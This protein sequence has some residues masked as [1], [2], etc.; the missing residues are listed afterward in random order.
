MS[1]LE[2]TQEAFLCHWRSFSKCLLKPVVVAVGGLLYLFIS[3][4]VYPFFSSSFLILSS[5]SGLLESWHWLHKPMQADPHTRWSRGTGCCCQHGI[6]T[7]HL[8]KHFHHPHALYPSAGPLVRFMT[9]QTADWHFIQVIVLANIKSGHFCWYI[10][11]MDVHEKVN[12]FRCNFS[13]LGKQRWC[14]EQPASKRQTLL[15]RYPRY[16]E[17]SKSPTQNESDSAGLANG[18]L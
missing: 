4:R 18:G 9:F 15:A 7:V 13:Q 3:V 5:C 17:T 6:H 12:T 2:F 10:Q 1:W 16:G 11:H 8:R 14:V